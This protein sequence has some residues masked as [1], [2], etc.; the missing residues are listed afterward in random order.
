MYSV[1]EKLD[2]KRKVYITID[3][4]ELLKKELL[5][6][7]K[8]GTKISKAKLLCNIVIKNYE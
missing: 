1:E 7:K 8:S 5:R 4:D 2:L 3:V 6:L